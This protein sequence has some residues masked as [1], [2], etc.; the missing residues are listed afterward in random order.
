MVRHALDNLYRRAHFCL[1]NATVVVGRPFQYHGPVAS[2]LST[3]ITGTNLPTPPPILT[4]TAWI[5]GAVQPYL[6][7]NP[8]K[9][10]PASPLTKLHYGSE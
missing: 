2:P 5:E 6:L 10:N 7:K 8:P 9:N 1:S 4:I 3:T